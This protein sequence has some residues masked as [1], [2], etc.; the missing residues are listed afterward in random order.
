MKKYLIILLMLSGCAHDNYEVVPGSDGSR[1][2][3][4]SDLVSCRWES[5]H[6]YNAAHP[7]GNEQVI[8]MVAG[9]ALGGALGG[10]AFGAASTGDEDIDK[11]WRTIDD[12]IEK[13]MLRKGYKGTTT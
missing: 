7:M 11:K 12:G 9:G 4:H 3:M 1:D 5:S 6:N 2:K 10:A 8:G 13:C